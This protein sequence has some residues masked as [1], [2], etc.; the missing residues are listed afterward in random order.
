M[1]SHHSCSNLHNSDFVEL[2]N[3]FLR[4]SQVGSAKKQLKEVILE[5]NYDG[6]IVRCCW[7]DCNRI[8]IPQGHFKILITVDQ[9]MFAAINGYVATNQSISSTINICD[10]GLSK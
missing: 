3:D 8:K 6:I 2:Q 4:V 1:K 9:F 5:F 10:F 7:N